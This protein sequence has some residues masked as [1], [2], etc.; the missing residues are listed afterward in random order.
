MS[1]QQIN[2]RVTDELKAELEKII[3]MKPG[4]SI[5]KFIAD[6]IELAVSVEKNMDS[7]SRSR[8]VIENPKDQPKNC[9]L[10]LKAM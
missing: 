7:H 9:K 2:I 1:K 5:N 4:A 6:A 8:L 3:G 10:L